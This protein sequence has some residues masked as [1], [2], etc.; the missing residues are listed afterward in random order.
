MKML[1]LTKYFLPVVLC[2]FWVGS[3]LLGEEN[4]RQNT[5]WGKFQSLIYQHD[6][7]LQSEETLFSQFEK[8]FFSD[9]GFVDSDTTKK[10]FANLNRTKN[11]NVYAR[12]KITHFQMTS[13]NGKRYTVHYTY[14]S[15]GAHAKMTKHIN[16]NG[17]VLK[18]S[19]TYNLKKQLLET[20]EYH[21]KKLLGQKLYKI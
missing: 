12:V 2:L 20:K 15:D 13:I 7:F 18:A 9:F 5:L 6:R 14:Q 1:K 21:N 3:G 17:K 8:V 19:Y 16:N 4:E 11:G 10:F